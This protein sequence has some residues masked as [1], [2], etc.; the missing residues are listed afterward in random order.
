MI[1]TWTADTARAHLPALCQLLQNVVDDGASIGFHLPL[2]YTEAQAYWEGILPG[3]EQGIRLLLV[4]TEGDQ[5]RG[6]VQLAL[7]PRANG[8]HRAEVQKLMVNTA[9]RRK[10]I[11]RQLML[12]LESRAREHNRTLLVLD[13]RQ[14]DASESLYQSED[15]T[16]AGVIPLYC[17]N[18]RGDLEATVLYYKILA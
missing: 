2:A 14:G 6:L 13:T 15:Y 4:D 7:E 18:E 9:C 11:A 8:R 10:G 5:L 3:I 1:A 16:Q 12:E 17:S